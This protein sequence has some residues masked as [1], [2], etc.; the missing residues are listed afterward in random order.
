MD[1]TY[2]AVKGSFIWRFTVTE[3][4]SELFYRR[5]TTVT[6]ACTGPEPDSIKDESEAL[7]MNTIER[8]AI[9]NGYVI[10]PVL[11]LTKEDSKYSDYQINREPVFISFNW[12]V[13]AKY[14]WKKS[15]TVRIRHFITTAVDRE[16]ATSKIKTQFKS[17]R[18][19]ELLSMAPTGFS[20]CYWK[21]RIGYPTIDHETLKRIPMPADL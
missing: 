18:F 10:M 4:D 12:E 11:I 5:W 21:N 19:L 16:D 6:E 17:A 3:T 2:E 13:T 8:W 1:R 14:K 9:M 7:L 15:N 20:F